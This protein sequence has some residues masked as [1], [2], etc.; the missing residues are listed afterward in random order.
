MNERLFGTDGIRGLANRHP[1]TAELALRVGCAVAYVF[2]KSGKSQTFLIGKDTRRSCYMIENALTAG[3]CSMGGRVLLTG[4]LPTPGVSYIM[5]SL[6]CDGAIMISASHN[7]FHDNGIKIFGADGYK[8]P[9]SLEAEI[10]R[11]V[12]SEE[13]DN[14]RPTGEGVGTAK[15]IDDAVGRYIEFAKATFPKGMRLD[16]LRVV[17]DCANGA[18]YKAGPN[19]LA[20]LGAEVIAIGNQPNGLNINDTCGA[21]YP[22]EMRA[23]VIREGADVGI[24]FDGDGDRIA[25]ADEHGRLLDGNAILAV[26]GIDMLERDVLPHRTVVTTIMANGGLE[27]ALAGHGGRVIRTGVGDRPVVEAMK[28]GGF[29]LGGEPSGHMVMLEH[30]TTGDALIAALQMLATMI[31]RDKPL[32]ALA[33]AYR[34]MPEAHRKIPRN[35]VGSLSETWLAEAA[36]QFEEKLGGQGRVVA[37]PSGTE[38]VIRLMVQHPE[39]RH[40]E[41]LADEFTAF[42][43]ATLKERAGEHAHESESA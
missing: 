10:A 40:A 30:N 21:V 13:L 17:V 27:E 22:A 16:G 14:G 12:Y 19:A 41:R 28:Q 4:P 24:A 2:G 18:A 8:I 15:R 25:M 3:L 5:R 23:T 43:L 11:L 9:D 29:T 34:E 26:L 1:M 42:L 35:D 32:S 31:R 6:R 37:R 7:P 36:R 33:Q 20:E 39:P 38:P